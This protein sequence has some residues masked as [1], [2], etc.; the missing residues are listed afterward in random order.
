MKSAIL[1]TLKINRSF[2]E[3]S[4]A[5]NISYL[6]DRCRYIDALHFQGPGMFTRA[7][8]SILQGRDVLIK[9]ETTDAMEVYNDYVAKIK[10]ENLDLKKIPESRGMAKSDSNSQPVEVFD[11]DADDIQSLYNHALKALELPLAN[12]SI[13]KNGLDT[14]RDVHATL[15]L[16]VTQLQ[17][18][19]T[20]LENGLVF[21]ESS[22]T[23]L[24][25]KSIKE[26]I[27]YLETVV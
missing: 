17:E 10:S 15:M 6:Q 9:D 22:S 21:A 3:M 4:F 19:L 8:K 5:E 27:D 13:L 11:I 14:C 25:F 24:P 26:A 23:G 1:T 16:E 2:S 18:E 7:N 12:G 20:S